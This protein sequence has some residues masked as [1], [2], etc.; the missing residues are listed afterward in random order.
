MTLAWVVPPWNVSARA[1]TRRS[2]GSI[3]QLEQRGPP[4]R[5]LRLRPVRPRARPAGG[6]L[7]DEIREQLRPGRGARCSRAS[8]TGSAPTSAIA[9]NWWT[10]WPL[11]DLPGCREKAYLVQD[12][13]PQFYATS[14]QS[15]S[16]PRRRY[17]MGYR[18]IAYTPWMAD[19]LRARLRHG[20]RAGSSAAPTSTTY[21]FG[22]GRARAG[23]DRRLRAPGDRAPRRRPRA[24]RASRRSFERRPGVRVDAVRL[25]RRQRSSPFAARRTSASRPPASSPRSTGARA[26]ASCSR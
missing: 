1:G 13:E 20:G 3:R 17:R 18:G 23:T 21:P 22:R 8:T 5:D 4:L 11:R 6:E 9:T 15:R 14:A 2:S 7:R 25:E 24:G 12:D 26:R 10:A 19:I 16:G